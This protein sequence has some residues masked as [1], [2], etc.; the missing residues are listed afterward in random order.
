MSKITSITLFEKPA[1]PILSVRKKINL[2]DLGSVA[3]DVYDEILSYLREID[4]YV[5]YAPFVCF[6]NQDL[7][8]LDVEI[9]FPIAKPLP[10]N[11][12]II[13]SSVPTQSVVSSIFLGPYDGFDAL[14][15]E[16]MDWIG[17][18]GYQICGPIYNYYL[19]DTDRPENEY[20]TEISIPVVK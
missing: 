17:T 3:S 7:E 6:H 19:N 20:L 18:N 4:E 8:Q 14:F 9:G 15:E 2:T 11:K 16:M 12:E 1:Q 13:A 5:S 10:G